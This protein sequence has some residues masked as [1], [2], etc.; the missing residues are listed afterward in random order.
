[1]MASHTKHVNELQPCI[2]ACNLCHT[3]CLQSAM[4]HCLVT[5]GK[6]VDADHFRLMM[7]CAEICQAS[8]NFQL[9][10]ST[11]H[12]ALCVICAD[13]CDACAKSCEAVGDME[14]C[15]KVCRECAASCR[16]MSS[17]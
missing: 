4:N 15:V 8:A 14:D 2:D 7:N 17:R 3:T 6:H 9:S 11:F 10:G 13:I 12:V 16:K 5:G 1:M